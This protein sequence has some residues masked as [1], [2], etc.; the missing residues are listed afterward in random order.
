MNHSLEI[1]PRYPERM[2]NSVVKPEWIIDTPGMEGT[3]LYQL[4]VEVLALRRQLAELRAEKVLETEFD[5]E[6]WESLPEAPP[7]VPRSSE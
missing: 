6:L 7:L 3:W 5:E 4:S 1:A 2:K